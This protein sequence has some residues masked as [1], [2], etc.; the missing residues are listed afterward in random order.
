MRTG[1]IGKNLSVPLE[2]LV[3]YQS[4]H[5]YMVLHSQNVPQSFWGGHRCAS[6]TF[7]NFP[8]KY[9]PLPL[10]YASAGPQ[11]GMEPQQGCLCPSCSC[12]W[13][14]S[15]PQTAKCLSYANTATIHSLLIL[16]ASHHGMGWV[17]EAA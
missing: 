13:F 9:L 1:I 12:L 5:E 10:T 2:L 6:N 17:W 7:T 8:I 4:G 3:D 15:A 11:L 14:I 16:Q